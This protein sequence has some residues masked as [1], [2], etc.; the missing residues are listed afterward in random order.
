MEEKELFPEMPKEELPGRLKRLRQEMEK[1]KTD[2]LI[3]TSY[4]DF[5]YIV[6]HL[7]TGW[8]LHAARP[9]YVLISQTEFTVIA[10]PSDQRLLELK[11]HAFNTV[12]Y[13]GFQREA[14]E[15]LIDTVKQFTK[16]MRASAAIDYGPEIFGMGNLQLID[17][18]RSMDTITDVISAADIVWRV[19]K[20]KSRYEAELKRRALAISDA[21]FEE[22]VSGAYCG[23]SER[24]MQRMIKI[25]MIKNGAERADAMALKFGRGDFL[26]NQIPGERRLQ[27]GH[28]VWG[29]FYNTYY[30]YPSD[31]CRIA[32][33]GEPENAEIELYVKVREVTIRL[34]KSVRTGLTCKEIYESFEQLWKEAELPEIWGAA[35][36]IGHSSGREVLEPTSIARWS[37]E[38]IEDGMILHFEPKIERLG[39]VYQFEEV[40]Y[41]HD[42]GSEFLTNL[43]PEEIPVIPA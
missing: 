23:I 30:G 2:I 34:C 28:Y 42:G 8:E 19:R 16:G 20:Y 4:A 36:R 26:F 41:V 9:M 10:S 35:G 3:F 25:S 17:G 38:V 39:G 5:E 18:L 15:M 1:Q 12:Y 43:S 29:D 21:A 33:C 14:T 37:N 22:A 27:E 32:R 31:R 11:E 24:E 7:Y 6:G 13:T 40:I